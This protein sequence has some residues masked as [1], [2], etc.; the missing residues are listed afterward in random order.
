MNFPNVMNPQALTTIHGGM[1]NFLG[2]DITE[3]NFRR[4]EPRLS[5][6][7]VT[8]EKPENSPVK[9]PRNYDAVYIELSFIGSKCIDFSEWGYENVICDISFDVVDEAVAIKIRCVDN[10]RLKFTCDLVRV[11]SV[12]HGLTGTP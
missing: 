2:S 9:W 12:R 1:P 10:S 11:E 3:V 8:R 6:K 4:D 7:L 5:I